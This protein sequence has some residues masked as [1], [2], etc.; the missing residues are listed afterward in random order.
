MNE[1]EYIVARIDEQINWYDRKSQQAQKWFKFLRGTEIVAAATIPV[2]AGFANSSLLVTFFIGVLGAGIAIISAVISL[3][4]FQENWTEY[5]TICESLKHEKFLFLTKTEPY[6]GA[7][8]FCLLVHRV[9]SLI[10][11]ENTAWSQYTRRSIESTQLNSN[12]S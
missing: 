7:Q 8:N 5:R 12:Q 10:S 11:K 4:Q 1:E 6:N 3:N 2:V 9:E